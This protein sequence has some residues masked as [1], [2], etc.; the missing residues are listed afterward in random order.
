V[1]GTGR[2]VRC[3][4]RSRSRRSG[5]T[6]IVVD[7]SVLSVA[8]GDDGADGATARASLPDQTLV[9]PE[10]IELEV[11]SVLRRRVRAGLMAPAR[12]ELTLTDLTEIPIRRA[13]HRPLLFRCWELRETVTPYDAADIALAEILG[14]ALLSADSRLSRVP[15]IRC[16]IEV[17]V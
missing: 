12:A 3:R 1:P 5:A 14:I 13:S 4:S 8:L 17:V 9:A 7:A 6:A 2:V 16:E 15:G 10:L 11:V